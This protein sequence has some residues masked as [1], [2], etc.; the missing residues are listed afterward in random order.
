MPAPLLETP[1]TELARRVRAREL[2]SE[3][4]VRAALARIEAENPRLQAFVELHPERAIRAA[5]EADAKTR[6]RTDLPPFHGIPIGI[7]DLNLVR[8]MR[9]RFGSKS[10][11]WLWSPIDDATTAQLRRAGFVILG[12][13]AT[14]ELGALPITEPAT[15]PPTRN[16]WHQD[17]TAGGSSGGSGAAVA[18]GLLPVA[19]GSDG[20][21]SIRIPSS[22]CGLVGHKPSRGRVQ[23]PFLLPGY[24]LLHTMGALARNVDDAAAMLDVMAGITVGRPSHWVP[25]PPRPF[26]EM[27]RRAPSRGQRIRF[28]LSNHMIETH[29]E[30]AAAV[31]RAVKLVESMGH[32]VEEGTLPRVP[33]DEFIPI[34]RHLVARLPFTNWDKTQPVTRWLGEP[35]RSIASRDASA[36]HHRLEAIARDWWGD[37]DCWITP[38]VP[39]PAPRVGEF[40]HLDAESLFRKLAPL[41]SFTAAFNLT[42]QPAVSIPGGV[43]SA[44]LP[45]GVQI[46]GRDFADGHVLAMAKQL[47]E[48]LAVPQARPSARLVAG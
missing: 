46:G 31:L 29:P 43:T 26:A 12:K 3:E 30:V 5:R 4:L 8:G 44:G 40:A 48:A 47:E 10:F 1:V 32:H 38:T 18:A 23:D 15:H 6:K 33:L 45:I 25:A 36:R 9:T 22:F 17:H 14:S 34:W 13:L 35:G 16:P 41:G 19:Q 7:K 2:S 28:A 24:R 20:A 27:A 42:G 39:V 21:G 11:D 37:A